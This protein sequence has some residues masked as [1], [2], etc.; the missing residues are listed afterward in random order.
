MF[1]SRGK[2]K[3]NGEWLHGCLLC[4]GISDVAA[5]VTYVNLSGNVRD[6]SE[7]NIHEIIP[8]TA[9]RYT[10]LTD[11]HNKPVFE[12]DRIK[13]VAVNSKERTGII[14]YYAGVWYI[15][16]RTID[17]IELIYELCHVVPGSIEVIG[18]I[19]DNPALIGDIKNDH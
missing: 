8:E 11:K 16:G 15:D 2:S 19:H 9:G 6:L 17:G 10:G 4:D 14:I 18:N 13:F 12:G 5:I 7:I 1:L 3:D